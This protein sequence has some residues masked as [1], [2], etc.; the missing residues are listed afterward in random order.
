MSKRHSLIIP[1]L[2]ADHKQALLIW[3]SKRLQCCWLDGKGFNAGATD[4][5]GLLGVGSL[6]ELHTHRESFSALDRFMDNRQDWLFGFLSYDLKNEIENLDSS[7]QDT[8]KLPHLHF[9]C[10]EFVF[11]LRIDHVQIHYPECFSE[12]TVRAMWDT[13]VK[14]PIESVKTAHRVGDVLCNF[15]KEEYIERVQQILRHIQ[16]G[17]IYEMNFCVDFTA[18][19]NSLDPASFFLAFKN[20][21]PNPFA[22]FYRYRDHYLMGASP[23]RFFKKTNDILYS[24]PMKGT[25]RRGKDAVEDA[26]FKTRLF[27]DE[28]ERAENVMIV[29]LVRNDLSKIAA[30]GSV[31]VDELFGMYTFPHVHQMISTVSAQIRKDV[32]FTDIVKALFPMGSMTGAPKIRAMQVIDA[33]ERN[34]RGLFS[35][36][37]GYIDPAGDMDFNVVIRSMQY[38]AD[39]G[40]L[41]YH[42]GSAITANSHPE[43]EYEECLLKASAF[44]TFMEKNT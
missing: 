5:I 4:R 14:T 41:S 40:M 3:A 36:S 32:F 8:F 35:G 38:Q 1:T 2:G 12:S 27:N 31:K 34:S 15:N 9:F 13:V 18:R 37:V 6:A 23:E 33:L 21:V 17:D 10:P 30:R 44:L 16:Q 39:S 19:L 22:C 24:Q 42:A 43:A 20:A 29:D 11:D 28:K 25:S 7:N 26:A